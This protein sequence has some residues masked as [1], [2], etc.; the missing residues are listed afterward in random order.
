MTGLLLEGK[1]YMYFVIF[2]VSIAG[3]LAIEFLGVLN[4]N[5]LS[6]NLLT[7]QLYVNIIAVS[8]LFIYQGYQSYS[9]VRIR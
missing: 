8:L 4:I 5:I 6:T 3:I 1:R 9:A 7:S 2:N